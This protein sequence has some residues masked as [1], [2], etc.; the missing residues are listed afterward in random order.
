MASLFQSLITD[1]IYKKGSNIGVVAV[2][3]LYLARV[4]EYKSSLTASYLT[5]SYTCMQ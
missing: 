1:D 5:A 4:R 3:L 2:A